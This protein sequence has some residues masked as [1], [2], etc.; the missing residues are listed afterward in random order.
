MGVPRFPLAILGFDVSLADPRVDSHRH[1][2]DFFLADLHR[3]AES[4]VRGAVGEGGP[5]EILPS[6]QEAGSLRSPQDLPAAVGDQVCSGRQVGVRTDQ[7]VGGSVN[8]Y[9][10]SVLLRHRHYILQAD[11]DLVE[12]IPKH[13]DKRGTGTDPGF[14]FVDRIDFYRL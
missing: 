12:A 13:H 2:E 3:A 7:N 14:H 10:N 5:D 9:R 11:P 6:Q 8:E 4:V 1:A